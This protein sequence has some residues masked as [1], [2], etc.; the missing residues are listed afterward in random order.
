M[1]K[2][3]GGIDRL[4][5]LSAIGDPELQMIAEEIQGKLQSVARGLLYFGVTFS[6]MEDAW[7]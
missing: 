5:W 7:A 2:V 1:P 3:V 4:A 6:G